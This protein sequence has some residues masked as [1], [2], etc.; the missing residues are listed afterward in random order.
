MSAPLNLTPR[1][2]AAL[3]RLLDAYVTTEKGDPGVADLRS[4]AAK[5][6]RL[7]QDHEAYEIGRKEGST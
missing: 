3:D 4:I 6:A 5:I 1:E 7:P 2:A